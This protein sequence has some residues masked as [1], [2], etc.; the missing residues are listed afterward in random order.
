M[1]VDFAVKVE[2]INIRH[3]RKEVQDRHEPVSEARVVDLV[4]RRHLRQEQ[5][6]ISLCGIEHRIGEEREQRVDDAV[7]GQ[8][9]VCHL[10]AAVDAR[11]RHLLAVA[12]GT[13]QARR[14]VVYER[15]LESARQDFRL[16]FDEGAH[17][18]PLER[19]D[20]AGTVVDDAVVD[21][22]FAGIGGFEAGPLVGTE[23]AKEQ[24]EEKKRA[25][26]SRK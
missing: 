10:L 13:E 4:L 25:K 16:V 12:V 26:K 1:A 11:G 2:C 5:L 17:A 3:A 21:V 15:A 19:I 14:Q 22:G 18:G 9:H 23:K 8:V 24:A 6:R 20:D 7:T